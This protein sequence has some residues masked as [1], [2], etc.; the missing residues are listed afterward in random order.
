MATMGLDIIYAAIDELNARSE[1]RVVIDKSPETKIFSGDD[2]LNSLDLV[3]LVIAIETHIEDS[4][5]RAV[6]IM[7]KSTMESDDNP[8]DNVAAL[9]V[10]IDNLLA[11]A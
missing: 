1:D 9:S 11:K 8:F 3:N 6:L 4:T 2:G 10:H 5:G 7:D